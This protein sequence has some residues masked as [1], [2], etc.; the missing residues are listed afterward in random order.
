MLNSIFI[1][2][3]ILGCLSLIYF[4]TNYVSMNKTYD[5]PIIINTSISLF[6]LLANRLENNR[7]DQLDESAF[8]VSNSASDS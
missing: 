5:N 4:L 1:I 3:N 7:D 2:D 6:N 8:H